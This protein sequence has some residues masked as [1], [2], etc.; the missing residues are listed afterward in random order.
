MVTIRQ[1]YDLAIK[2]GTDNDLRGR[3]AV[4]RKL[5]R[6]RQ[7]FDKLS[8]EEQREYDRE[9][10]VNPFS[11]TRMFTRH[12]ETPVR[13]ILA[14]ID[15]E[16]P[17]LLLA[18]ELARQGKPVDL[19][20]SHHPIGH[21]LAGLH[22]VMHLQAEVLA[23]YGVPINVAESLMHIRMSEV[24]RSLDPYNHSRVTDAGEMLGLPLICVHTPADNMVASYLQRHIV[25]HRDIET[26]G[27]LLRSLK[28]IPEYRQAIDLKMG[29]TLYV[30]TPDRL[31]GKI[32]LTEITGG[33]DGSKEM[34][35]RLS[36]AGVGTIVGMHMRDE[37]KKEAEKHHIS[38]VNAGHM[39]SDSLGVN[40]FLDELERRGV[41][42]VPCSGLIRV[43]RNRKRQ[44]RPAKRRKR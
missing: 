4:Q 7:R 32:A 26:V 12:P 1:I 8:A 17:E 29:P 16:T 21:A 39:S 40:L 42:I 30:G 33:T 23:G 10:L 41:E 5:R 20:F 43:S 34:Y 28:E 38:V 22:E 13:R 14:G 36:Q 11:D 35:E 27:D 6:E 44:P 19:V 15:I 3:A 37:Y 2:L 25:R 31:T 9:N 18:T 24:S